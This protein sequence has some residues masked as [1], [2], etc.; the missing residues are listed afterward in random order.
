MTI[1]SEFLESTS[2]Q[3]STCPFVRF[4]YQILI[5]AEAVMT[6]VS[7]EKILSV[8]STQGSL[9]SFCESLDESIHKSQLLTFLEYDR[10]HYKQFI[11]WVIPFLS[12]KL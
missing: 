11:S 4:N 3:S 5:N 6:T 2:G 9:K 8:V 12:N 10:D 7:K 1:S